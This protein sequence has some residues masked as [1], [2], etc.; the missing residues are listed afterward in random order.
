ML[1]DVCKENEATFHL[2][3]V[4]TG[5]VQKVDLCEACAKAKGVTDTAG[6]S[7]ADL[8]VG[9]GASKEIERTTPGKAAQCPECG[10]TQVD[11]KK[12]GRLG[13]PVCWTTFEEGLGS[14][15]KT[16]HKGEQHIGKVPAR[17]AKTF[18]IVEKVETLEA[19]LKKAIA[20]E[21]YEE[22]ASLRDRIQALQKKV[23]R[24]ATLKELKESKESKNTPKDSKDPKE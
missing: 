15:L 5:K 23:K 4:I 18:Q 13:C 21:R 8:V 11:F 3:Q 1:C 16:I 24:Q 17:A 19:D 7:L 2:T 12:T 6:F 9:L 20:E 14:L 22:A 10:F